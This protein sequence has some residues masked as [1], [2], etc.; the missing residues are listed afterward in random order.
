VAF[1]P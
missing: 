1:I